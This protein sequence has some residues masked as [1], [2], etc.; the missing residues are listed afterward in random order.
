AGLEQNGTMCAPGELARQG[1]ELSRR[2]EELKARIFEYAGGEFN[3]DSPKQLGEVLFEKLGLPAGKRTKTGYSTDIEVLTKLAAE[4]DKNDP[5]TLVP[6]LLIEYR[7]L[8]K[9]INTYLGN[10]R[11]SINPKTGRIHSTF[12]QQVKIGR[13]SCR[14]RVPHR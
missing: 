7:Q 11:E 10:L 3:L 4:E 1:E 6:G 2:V 13:A 8:S 12:H 14:E 9:L 5:K